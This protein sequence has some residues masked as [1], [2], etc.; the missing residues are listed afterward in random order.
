MALG[1]DREPRASRPTLLGD[2]CAVPAGV[3]WGEGPSVP[4]MLRPSWMPCGLHGPWL[5]PEDASLPLGKPASFLPI[6]PS[7]MTLAWP[8]SLAS[9]PA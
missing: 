7:T 8:T 9:L 1:I 4:W 2:R 5:S 3:G 6:M